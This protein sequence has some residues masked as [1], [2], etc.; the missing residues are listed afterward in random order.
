MQVKGIGLYAIDTDKE[1]QWFEKYLDA[2][3]ISSY[4]SEESESNDKKMNYTLGFK[5][6]LQL[7]I[8]Y[9]PKKAE[10][11]GLFFTGIHHIAFSLGSE[12]KV[13]ELT[14]KL[15]GDGFQVI[16]GPRRTG[17]GYW[18]SCV[19]DPEGNQIELTV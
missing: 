5:E 17:D 12:D 8:R 16:S 10:N 14:A 2:H 1:K 19:Y 15:K 13:N 18:E 6:G 7:E 11:L 3:V 9:A 4:A